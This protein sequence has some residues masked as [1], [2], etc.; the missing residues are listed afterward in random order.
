MKREDIS[1]GA[2]IKLIVLLPAVLS[3]L[4]FILELNPA[5]KPVYRYLASSREDEKE[6]IKGDGFPFG[7]KRPSSMTIFYMEGDKLC[8]DYTVN[9]FYDFTGRLSAGTYE[10]GVNIGRISYQYSGVRLLRRKDSLIYSTDESCFQYGDEGRIVRYI[11]KFDHKKQL[12]RGTVTEYCYD[13]NGVLDYAVCRTVP[14]AI[15]ENR[16]MPHLILFNYGSKR[17]ISDQINHS[18]KPSEKP[19]EIF[20]NSELSIL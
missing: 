9:L 13:E 16:I 6:D 1:R 11:E 14:G 5:V 15:N 19:S 20:E 10:Y 8:E 17:K 2:V 4:L 18:E 7:T 12:A 3:L